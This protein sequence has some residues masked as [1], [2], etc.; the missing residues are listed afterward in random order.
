MTQILRR[1][2]AKRPGQVALSDMKTSLGWDELADLCEQSVRAIDS[3]GLPSG[4]RIA[5][6]MRNSVDAALVFLMARFAGVELTA[7][8][9]HLT[10]VELEYVFHDARVR[11]VFCDPT[12]VE[13]VASATEALGI[14]HVFVGDADGH[15]AIQ[16]GK[17]TR[18]REWL[19]GFPTGDVDLTRAATPNLLYTSGTTG[20]PKG[21]LTPQNLSGTIDEYIAAYP[22]ADDA[23]PFLTVGPLYHAGPLG[24]LRR[25]T[26]GRPLVVMRHFDP[27]E[28]L[29]AIQH[30]RIT[31]ATFVPTHFLRMLQLDDPTRSR[32]DVSSLRFVD[33]TGSWCPPEVKRSMIDWFG[34]VLEERY[35]GTESG[36]VCTI[37]SREWLDHPGSVGRCSSRF[38]AVVVDDDGNELP[39]GHTGRLFFAD[40]TG[41][42]VVYEND[43]AK[44][45]AAHLRPGV[46][47]LGDIGHVDDE[48][49]V[50]VTGRSADLIV[51]GG[52]NLYP[53]EIE[54]VLLGVP[55]VA[56]VAVVGAPDKSMGERAVA[57]VVPTNDT[58]T[59]EAV[60]EQAKRG[61]AG[62]K[63]PRDIRFVADLPR[64]PM[65]KLDRKSLKADLARAAEN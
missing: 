38:T 25:L 2:A 7:L 51:S 33:H 57:F 20:F 23:G 10:P 14:P 54:R 62:P 44:T 15:S 58:L 46:F 16:S 60:I 65:G 37:G 36:T 22:E 55:G 50:F 31:G 8:S 11:A 53:A 43:P 4:S 61:L 28:A 41:R 21:V 26:A 27:V 24:S 32:F 48:G 12:T 13:S 35:G 19:A 56:D 52:V 34:P 3:L 5:V 1:V 42:G 30:H 45:A 49:Y 59:I 39:R 17:T 6:V 63:V 18:F 47:T 29:S 64:N 9:Y 40:A